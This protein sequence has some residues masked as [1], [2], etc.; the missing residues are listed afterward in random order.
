[1]S[2]KHQ[3]IAETVLAQAQAMQAGEA[4]P[5]AAPEG[6]DSVPSSEAEASAPEAEAAPESEAATPTKRRNLSWEEAVKAVPPDIAK[7]MKDLRADY[8][9]KTQAISDERKGWTHERE[10]LMAGLAELQANPPAQDH[11]DYDPFNEQAM[12][13]RIELEVNRRLKAV[14]EPMQRKV[15][16]MKAEEGYQSFLNANPDF[17]TDKALRADVQAML[18]KNKSLDLETAYWAAKGRQKQEQAQ[19]Q[20]DT[21][22]ARRNAAREAALKGTAP[23]RRPPTVGK[24]NK[25]DLRG[26]SAGDIYRLAQ[27]MHADK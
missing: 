2:E 22:A 18:E 20:R 24:P 17:K 12:Q 27:A 21:R 19:T 1:M 5:Q 13:Q 7:L 26:M 16:T 15:A 11:G 25:K 8:T 3:S 6:T 23:S 10:A 4:A 14:L 9:R